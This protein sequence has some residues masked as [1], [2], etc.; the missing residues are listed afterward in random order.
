MNFLNDLSPL[1]DMSDNRSDEYKVKLKRKVDKFLEENDIDLSVLLEDCFIN[2]SNYNDFIESN[3]ADLSFTNI[4]DLNTVIDEYN[5]VYGKQK[6]YFNEDDRYCRR[7]GCH[8]YDEEDL[9]EEHDYED[10]N[11]N[12]LSD[13]ELDSL[14][15]GSNFSNEIDLENSSR[16]KKIKFL[17]NREKFV[18]NPSSSMKTV[19]DVKDAMNTL[20][21]F[22]IQFAKSAKEDP[23]LKKKIGSILPF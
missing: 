23:N 6:H 20:F 11:F 5:N 10:F 22:V 9:E 1:F 18:T 17:E 7:N 4:M 19:D 16:N 8:S 21:D 14:I 12:R 3:G 13:D 15:E 2:E